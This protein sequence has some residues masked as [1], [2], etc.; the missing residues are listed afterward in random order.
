VGSEYE[1]KKLFLS[2]PE[3]GAASTISNQKISNQKSPSH[4]P[5][6]LGRHNNI[7]EAPRQVLG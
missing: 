4:D 3:T 6:Y 5:C 7:I 2:Q 1:R